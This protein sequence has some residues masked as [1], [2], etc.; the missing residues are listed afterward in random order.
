M[1]G[2]GLLMGWEA[3][4]SAGIGLPQRYALLRLKARIHQ[5]RVSEETRESGQWLFLRWIAEREHRTLSGRSVEVR[6]WTLPG[7]LA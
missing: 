2:L 7:P 3:M 4:K 5:H 6:P 1:D